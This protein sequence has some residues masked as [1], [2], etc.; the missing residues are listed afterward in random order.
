MEGPQLWA[1]FYQAFVNVA[2]AQ[3]LLEAVKKCEVN[4]YSFMILAKG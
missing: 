1:F 2:V 3:R 4:R